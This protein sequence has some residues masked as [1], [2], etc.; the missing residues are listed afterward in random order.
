MF[1][2]TDHKNLHYGE[3]R[4]MRHYRLEKRIQPHEI[5]ISFART[6]FDYIPEGRTNWTKKTASY[7]TENCDI[8]RT[9]I[10]S[11]QSK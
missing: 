9:L 5:A 7:L 6:I 11:Y 8:L 3:W 2:L 10:F 4:K 1:F